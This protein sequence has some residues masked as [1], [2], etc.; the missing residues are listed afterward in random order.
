MPT[1]KPT[2]TSDETEDAPCALK[3]WTDVEE[4]QD[5]VP[6]TSESMR[7][8]GVLSSCPKLSPATVVVAIDVLPLLLTPR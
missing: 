1:S 4:R 8:L 7:P 6:H 3:Q 2:V 5:V